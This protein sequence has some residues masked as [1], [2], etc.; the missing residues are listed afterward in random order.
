VSE[1]KRQILREW[2]SDNNNNNNNNNKRRRTS[3]ALGD[4]SPCLKRRNRKRRLVS[5]RISVMHAAR[6]ADGGIG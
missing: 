1:S 6:D 5:L 3:M 2:K 4:P